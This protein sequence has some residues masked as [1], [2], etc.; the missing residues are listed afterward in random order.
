MLFVFSLNNMYDL[1]FTLIVFGMRWDMVVTYAKEHTR[2]HNSM[3]KQ[4]MLES[5]KQ[6][7]KNEQ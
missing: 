4:I 3:E 2:K 7:M 1:Y 6:I 5:K